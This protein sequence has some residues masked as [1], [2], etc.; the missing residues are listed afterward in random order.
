MYYLTSLYIQLYKN[1][2]RVNQFE[3]SLSKMTERLT[4][5]TSFNIEVKLLKE[6]KRQA[7]ETDK[8]QTELIH[9]Y[10]EEGLKRDRKQTT[11][12]D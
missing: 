1:K 12:Y 3:G 2:L 8:T 7:F 5:K 11:L 9:T 10:I 4:K 6:L